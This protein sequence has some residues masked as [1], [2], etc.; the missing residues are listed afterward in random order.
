MKNKSIL[1]LTVSFTPY[2]EVF[3]FLSL[4]FSLFY[5]FKAIPA[6]HR[7]KKD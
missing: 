4:E 3:F 2:L 1:E 6:I 5:H 7:S